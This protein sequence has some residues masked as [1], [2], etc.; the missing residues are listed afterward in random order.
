LLF[1]RLVTGILLRLPWLYGPCPSGLGRCAN[2][3]ADGFHRFAVRRGPDL[4]SRFL[5]GLGALFLSAAVLPASIVNAVATSVV[6][7]ET[8]ADQVRINNVAD[9]GLGITANAFSDFAGADVVASRATD[10][11][12]V[13]TGYRD[14]PGLAGSLASIAAILA[15]IPSQRAV[16][17]ILFGPWVWCL[18]AWHLPPRSRRRARRVRHRT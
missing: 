1:C 5:I 17:M 14:S 9:P 10:M 8:F 6:A 4:A 16:W 18:I 13:A 7:A 2:R 11:T 3:P 15:R 12:A